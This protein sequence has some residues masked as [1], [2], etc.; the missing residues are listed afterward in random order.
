VEGDLFV[1]SLKEDKSSI[2][3]VSLLVRPGGKQRL[4]SLV[5]LDP[6][7]FFQADIHGGVGPFLVTFLAATLHWTPDRIGTVMF[8]SG[9]AGLCAQ[10]PGGALVDQLKSKRLI[11]AVSSALIPLPASQL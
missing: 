11:V 10:T 5:A 1:E 7:N 3:S 8:A 2:R 4:R 9:I 6:L